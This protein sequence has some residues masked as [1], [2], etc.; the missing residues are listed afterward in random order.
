V[1]G[2]GKREK[3]PPLWVEFGGGLGDTITLM[4]TSD[5]YNCL[6]RLE[7][8]EQATVLCTSHNPFVPE[9][10]RWHPKR[11]QITVR[12]VGFWWPQEDAEKR[13]KLGLPPAQP[14]VFKL[15]EKCRFY[16]SGAD[17]RWVRDI[18]AA[19]ERKPYVVIAASAGGKD[20]NVPLGLCEQFVDLAVAR[21]YTVLIVGRTYGENRHEVRPRPRPHVFDLVDRL[22]VPGTGALL[23]GAGAVLAAHSGMCLLSWYLKKP[24]LLLYPQHV[25]DTHFHSVHQYTFGKDFPSTRHM[26]F[27]ECTKDR[28]GEFFDQAVGSAR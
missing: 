28:I 19:A 4:Y 26:L 15:Q 3:K 25:R 1:F 23:E 10:F 16:P 22:S 18:M 14:F 13:A 7:P 27:S 5:R 21:G 17:D 20:R 11:D 9:L 8:G 2:I 6:E 24:T 12:D